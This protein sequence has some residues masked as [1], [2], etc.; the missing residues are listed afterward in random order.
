MLTTE[1]NLKCKYCS[2]ESLNDFDEVFDVGNIDYCLP[3][4]NKF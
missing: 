3:K 1:C 2:G 4:K